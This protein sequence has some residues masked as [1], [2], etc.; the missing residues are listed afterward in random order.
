MT[1]KPSL[2]ES[3]LASEAF[4]DK[5]ARDMNEAFLRRLNRPGADGRAY[6]SFILDWLYLERPL[7]ER[8]RGARYQVQFEGP[9]ITI[10]GQDFPLGAYIYR[11]LEWAH[12]DPVRA[13]DLYEKLRAAVDAAVEEWR[14]QTPLK[15]LPAHPQRPFADRADA[16]AKAAQAIHAFASPARKPE[17]DNDA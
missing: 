16:D 1:D 5:I 13:H 10:D 9:A 8:F 15:F 2:I 6:R 11:K 12:I 17:G 7:F 3:I 4:Q 14:G